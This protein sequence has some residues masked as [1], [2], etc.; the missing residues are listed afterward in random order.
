MEINRN[1][2]KKEFKEKYKVDDVEIVFVS[3]RDS[4]IRYF[5][6]DGVE[7]KIMITWSNDGIDRIIRRSKNFSV[8]YESAIKWKRAKEDRN[9]REREEWEEKCRLKQKELTNQISE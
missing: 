8:L 1:L 7:G 3:I 9:K 6:L 5:V 2:T 4:Y